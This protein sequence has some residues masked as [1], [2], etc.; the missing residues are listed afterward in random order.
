M[1]YSLY[2]L[3]FTSGC[4][5]EIPSKCSLLIIVDKYNTSCLSTALQRQKNLP[6]AAFKTKQFL[7][8]P[9]AKGVPSSSKFRSP[10]APSPL[11]LRQPVKAFSNHG[12]GSV[13]PLEATQ[14]THSSS[15]PG[16]LAAQS[17]GLPGPASGVNSTTLTRPAGTVGMRSSLPRPSAPST[18]GIPV[19][20]SKLAQPVRRS[21][22]A[23]KTYS[24]M[25]DES[26][27][28]GCYWTAE[29]NAKFQCS[30][31]LPHQANTQLDSTDCSDVTFG[32]CINSKPL[33]L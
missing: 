2:P 20:R 26:W 32:I 7:Q 11:A 30:W 12:P 9:S 18:G 14:L 24:N 15:S 10:A 28:D 17:S 23:P 3:S 25:K 8:T 31:M 5:S 22:P 33:C 4:H 1:F 6:R 29:L 13:A 21:L 16:P 27:K 19:P